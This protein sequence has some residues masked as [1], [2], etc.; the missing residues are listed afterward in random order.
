MAEW[1]KM[2]RPTLVAQIGVRFGR[3]RARFRQSRAKFGQSRA[4]SI[5]SW[6]N[7]AGLGPRSEWDPG[8]GFAE[9]RQ[10]VAR[11]QF[12]PIPGRIWPSSVQT[13]PNLGQCWSSPANVGRVGSDLGRSWPKSGQMWASPGRIRPKSADSWPHWQTLLNPGSG[14]LLEICEPLMFYWRL[15][16]GGGAT[17]PP[18]TAQQVAPWQQARLIT[19]K[20]FSMHSR[21]S[22][23]KVS[24]SSMPAATSQFS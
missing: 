6:P 12:R 18:E 22:P 5:D 10:I 17:I 1:S 14:T 16:H 3:N 9:I 15:H 2:M 4:S 13:W 23:T 21:S 7:L 19:A 8:R 11:G 24:R 20:T